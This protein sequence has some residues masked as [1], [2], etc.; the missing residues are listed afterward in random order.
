MGEDLTLCSRRE[1][2][3]LVFD[4]TGRLD[5]ITTP[6]AAGQVKD[7]IL[8][9]ERRILLNFTGLHYINSEGLRML[10]TGLKLMREREG[11]FLIACLQPP[12]KKI[13]EVAGFD[14]MFVFYDRYNDAIEALSRP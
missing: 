5:D 6:M 7:A 1:G 12:I 8:E 9:G 2:P 3:V 4:L 13:L 11:K 14:R 10:V